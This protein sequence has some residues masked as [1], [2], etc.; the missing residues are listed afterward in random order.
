MINDLRNN[1]VNNSTLPIILG[2]DEQHQFVRRRPTVLNTHRSTAAN[3]SKIEFTSMI[4]LP[5]ADPTHLTPAGLITHGTRIFT[6]FDAI[7]DLEVLANDDSYSVTNP[8]I[9]G[10]TVG[11]RILLLM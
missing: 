9:S 6:A 7:D 2:I 10:A 5:K 8:A 11:L 3:D 1:V 4:G